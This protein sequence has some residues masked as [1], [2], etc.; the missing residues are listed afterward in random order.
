MRHGSNFYRCIWNLK[1]PH[2]T[3]SIHQPELYNDDDSAYKYNILSFIAEATG[4]GYSLDVLMGRNTFATV[5]GHVT[6]QIKEM[7]RRFRREEVYHDYVDTW[8]YDARLSAEGSASLQ[9]INSSLGPY[10]TRWDLESTPRTT[11]WLS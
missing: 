4:T 6:L 3:S 10:V 2:N 9:A 1:V 7:D 11:S 5:I 8:V